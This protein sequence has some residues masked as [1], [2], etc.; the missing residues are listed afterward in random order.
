MRLGLGLHLALWPR[1]AGGIVVAAISA[2]L[3]ETGD[4]LAAEN[5][6]I[7]ILE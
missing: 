3:G 4:Q 6:D 5:N 2:L 1:R 7:L